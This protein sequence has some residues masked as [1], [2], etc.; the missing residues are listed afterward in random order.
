MITTA[1]LFRHP[2]RPVALKEMPIV[3]LAVGLA[4]DTMP[5]RPSPRGRPTLGG[6]LHHP[7][8]AVTDKRITEASD[9]TTLR[10]VDR[11]S[12]TVV[13]A[14]DQGIGE[15]AGLEWLPIVSS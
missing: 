12:E 1:L 6:L 11:T 9:P 4:S 8:I 2:T 10:A 13:S 15:E 3:L 7:A 14:V 5:L